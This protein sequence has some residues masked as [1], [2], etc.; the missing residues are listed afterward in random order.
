M[1][2]RAV[3]TAVTTTALLGAGLAGAHAGTLS[4]NG[5]EG[6]TTGDIDGQQGWTKTGPY[7]VNIVE[8]TGTGITDMGAKALQMS[9]ATVSGSFGDQTF[10]APVADEAGE[11]SA[12]NG[13]LSGGTRQSQ[14]TASFSLRTMSA[15]E[16]EGLYVSIS[17]DRGD[18]ARMSYLRLE[19]AAEGV[20]VYFDD[21][22][23]A[24]GFR[25]ELVATLDRNDK[26]TIGL[27]IV[28]VDGP[29]ND[30]VEVTVDGDLVH[31]GTSWEDYFR[32]VERTD[33]RTVDSL[34]FRAGGSASDARPELLGEGFLVDD[35]VL[36]SG[37]TCTFTDDGSTMTLLN[38]CTTDETIPVP[39]GYTLDGNGHTITAVDPSGD[40]FLGAVV[41]NDGTTASVVDLGVT[42]DVASAC[43]SGAA[44]LAGIQL[45]GASGT[46]SGN[47]V[48]GIEQGASG[49]G[50]QEGNAID[51]RNELATRT[52]VTIS[53]NAV[54]SYQKTGILV[55]GPIHETLTGNQV[56]GYGPVGFIAQNGVQVS[57]G[58]S[59]IVS[60]NFVSDNW[61]TGS[62]TI[63]CGVLLFDAGGVK[64]SKNAYAGN[65]RDVCNFGKGGGKVNPA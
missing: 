45:D 62:G 2:L 38:D 13:G 42:A 59:A 46:I 49:D 28:F 19:D 56:D 10:S 24:D 41:A 33:P 44:R 1:R 14:F 5:F 53:D 64:V 43:H 51:V 18:G 6:F 63:S 47:E 35:L 30:V 16:H 11:A 61:Y 17:P 39:D 8:L 40:N 7:D 32:D 54:A 60:G 31:T 4:S 3:L 65:Q 27:S 9:N 37:E 21:Y 26:H 15:D 29:A 52:T 55:S 22:T 25:E 12:E 58:A 57:R 23:T 36:T 50:C 20:E 48:V 34:L